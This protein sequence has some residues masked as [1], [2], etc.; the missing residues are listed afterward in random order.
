MKGVGF[1]IRHRLKRT[2][3]FHPFPLFFLLSSFEFSNKSGPRFHIY[4]NTYNEM[5][6]RSRHTEQF[7]GTVN[8]CM[9]DGDNAGKRGRDVVIDKTKRLTERYAV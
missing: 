7:V 8:R 2:T 1:N 3:D 9:A 6:A 5:I 4:A